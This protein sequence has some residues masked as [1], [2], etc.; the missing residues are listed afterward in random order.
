M[1]PGLW[2]INLP[3]IDQCK[4]SDFELF[5][6]L[7]KEVN[8][9]H[10]L[11][12]SLLTRLKFARAFSSL[13]TRRQYIC[14]QLYAFMILVQASTD[15]DDLVVFFNNELEFVILT[16]VTS[17]GHC[18]VLSSLMHMTVDYIVSGSGDVSIDFAGALLSL[19]SVLVSSTPG[20]LALKKAGYIPTIL[21]LLKDTEPKHL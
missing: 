20:S 7:V 4:E 16:S 8:V 14:I 1:C 13:A 10:N 17:G 11:R 12:F 2:V 9:P 3:K 15:A 6:E 5:D 18:G 21:P 19:V